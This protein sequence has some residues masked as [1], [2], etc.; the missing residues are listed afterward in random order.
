[1]E[2]RGAVNQYVPYKWAGESIF[3]INLSAGVTPAFHF[4]QGRE[5]SSCCYRL[6]G[7]GKIDIAHAWYRPKRVIFD[8][9]SV[10]VQNH[11]L[12]GGLNIDLLEIAMACILPFSL[13]AVCID[14]LRNNNYEE[15][16]K[17]C[18]DVYGRRLTTH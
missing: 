8:K 15:F 6:S 5:Y 9:L 12:N 4:F 10:D 3:T 18:L 1:M 2:N 14:M 16:Q 11:V 7:V 13:D 17:W